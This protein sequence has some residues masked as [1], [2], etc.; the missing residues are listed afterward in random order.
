MEVF[1]TK[2]RI[3]KPRVNFKKHFNF[4]RKFI[5][6]VRQST[7]PKA[8]YNKRFFCFLLFVLKPYLVTNIY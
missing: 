2:K 5:L 6:N 4:C 3:S 8:I 7:A 1:V